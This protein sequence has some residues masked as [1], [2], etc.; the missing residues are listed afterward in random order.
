MSVDDESDRE[1]LSRFV[2]RARIVREHSLATS[3]DVLKQWAKM[4]FQLV[5]LVNKVTGERRTLMKR[6][7]L[8]PT[9]QLESAAARVRPIYLKNDGVHYS[10]PIAALKRLNP[11]D[12]KQEELLDNSILPQFQEA[13]L[14][15]P[16]GELPPHAPRSNKDLAGSWLYGELLHDD[17]VRR[18][19]G[20]PTSIEQRYFAAM[21]LIC[22]QM[23]P[24][25]RLLEHIETAHNGGLL[26]LPDDV[27]T[28]SVIVTTPALP[29]REVQIYWN[30]VGVPAPESVDDD[31]ESSGWEAA[32][33]EE[34]FEYKPD[35]K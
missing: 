25:V 31:L 22:S 4:E 23:I 35:D 17:P 24:V 21:K 34:V 3:L 15:R 12:P 29:P 11:N 32:K 13:D 28:K 2:L 33:F 14:D 6:V 30:E 8:I 10:K 20:E 7:P 19:I 1:L 26:G 16:K 9:E 18:S 5:Q 27:F